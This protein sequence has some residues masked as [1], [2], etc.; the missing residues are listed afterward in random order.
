MS[1]K[2]NIINVINKAS[3]KD[4]L[5][6]LYFSIALILFGSLGTFDILTNFISGTNEFS[7]FNLIIGIIFTI[8]ALLALILIILFLLKPN[9]LLEIDFKNQSIIINSY[10][11]KKEI[12]NFKDLYFAKINDTSFLGFITKYGVLKLYKRNGKKIT[13]NFVSN[14]KTIKTA[15]EVLL[16]ISDKNIYPSYTFTLPFIRLY[17]YFLIIFLKFVHFSK[18]KVLNSYEDIGNVLIKKQITKV[19]LVESNTIHNKNLD[20]ELI[21]ILENKGINFTKL[22]GIHSNP[23]VEDVILG[24]EKFNSENCEAIIAIGGGSIIDASKGIATIAYTKKDITKFK[25]IFK[26][27]HKIPL[28]IAIPTTCG[29]GSETTFV[30]V[31]TNEKIAKKFEIISNKITPKYTLLDEKLLS[32]LPTYFIASTAMD[33]FCHALESYLNITRTRKTKKESLFAMRLIKEN[34]IESKNNKDSLIY[35]RNLLNASF[36]AGKAFNRAFVG[37]IHALSHAIGGK[38]NL[39][40]GYLNAILMPRFLRVYLFTLYKDM[41]N[42]ARYLN[43]SNTNDLHDDAKSLIVYLESIISTFEFTDYIN[44]LNKADIRELALQ[45][46]KEAHLLYPSK[47]FVNIS[48]YEDIMLSLLKK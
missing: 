21:K 32:T 7:Y 34:L 20:I 13:I 42:I 33:A 26:I 27:R 47:K 28:L 22:T 6:L 46:Y 44:S 31:L 39:D 25:G 43:L 5:Y 37:P 45:A 48:M 10:F 8:I 11:N 41:A 15:L 17:Q 29:T 38:Y 23:C 16:N 18:P 4:Y 19:L 40:H 1:N 12:L 9:K 30:S 2:E 24:K 14:A 35:K 3:K 36:I